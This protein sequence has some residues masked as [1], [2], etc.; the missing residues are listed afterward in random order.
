MKYKNYYSNP[1]YSVTDRTYSGEVTGLPDIPKIVAGSLDDYERLFHQAVDD[2]LNLSGKGRGK[3]GWVIAGLV[4]ALLV[5][6]AVT[7]PKKEKHVEVLTDRFAYVV[8]NQLGQYDS[9]LGFIG[10]LFGGA[11]TKPVVNSYLNVHNYIIFNVGTIRYKGE[12]NAISVGAFGHVFT[13]SREE[14]NKK[15][16]EN[17][18]LLEFLKSLF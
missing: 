1:T 7:C 5:I 14:W 12:D 17:L 4:G 10:S 9:G 6:M 15:V 13:L 2:H 16:E 8:K 3:T 18:D 11:V